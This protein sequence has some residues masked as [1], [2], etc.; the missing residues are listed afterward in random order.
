MNTKH[1]KWETTMSNE[2][3]AKRLSVYSTLDTT[4]F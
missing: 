3:V 2:R 4:A 1:K